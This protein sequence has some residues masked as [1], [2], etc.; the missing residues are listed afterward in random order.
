VLFP[1]QTIPL[2]IFEIRYKQ[3]LARC[4]KEQIPFGIVLIPESGRWGRGTPRSI[5]TFARVTQVE[6][7]PD[8]RCI[9]PA[10]HNGNCFHI[11]CFGEGRFRVSSL[12]R[13]EAEYLVGE[14]EPY[15]DEESPAPAMA[16]VAG[17]VSV[18]FDDYYRHLVALM[19][20]WQREAEPNGRTLL[21]DM[22]TLVKGQAVLQEGAESPLDKPRRIKV[23][24]LPDDPVALANAVAAE[25]NVPPDVKQELLETPSALARLQREAEILADETPQMQERLNQQV[26]RRFTSFGMSS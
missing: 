18:L 14:V 5:G 4:L 3:M 23:P 1:G 6:E 24:A 16:M 17:R 10:P 25:L 19:G 15:P 2:H 22:S 8:G 12:D 21:F 9:I 11:S 13:R 26:R 20:G 7:V